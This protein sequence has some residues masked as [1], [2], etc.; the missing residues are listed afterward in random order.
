ML[1]T[2]QQKWLQAY[3]HITLSR[4]KMLSLQLAPLL[5]GV[6]RSDQPRMQTG[7]AWTFLLGIFAEGFQRNKDAVIAAGIC[8]TL[9]E[10]RHANGSTSD[11]GSSTNRVNE[12][13]DFGDFCTGL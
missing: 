3:L 13:S 4:A 6:S 8:F 10:S 9:C 7:A 1:S 2:R 11:S 5:V 12:V